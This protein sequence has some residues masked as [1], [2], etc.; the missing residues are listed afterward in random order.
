LIRLQPRFVPRIGSSPLDRQNHRL[1]QRLGGERFSC[2][3][4][5]CK[6]VADARN[7]LGD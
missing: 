2:V 5:H 7:S 4:Q 3:Q 6:L 1:K